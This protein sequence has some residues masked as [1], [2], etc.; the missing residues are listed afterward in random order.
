MTPRPPR[1]KRKCFLVWKNR[2]TPEP[3][4]EDIHARRYPNMAAA[5]TAAAE[6]GRLVT[7]CVP[8]GDPRLLMVESLASDG[9]DGVLG[10]D[11]ALPGSP[12]AMAIARI[13][14]ALQKRAADAVKEADQF[15][16]QRG[17]CRSLEPADDTEQP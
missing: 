14:A 2:A 9:L 13:N 7:E 1:D 10:E 11:L 4:V 16:F 12:M 8:L 5:V 17:Y 6:T 15:D 3:L